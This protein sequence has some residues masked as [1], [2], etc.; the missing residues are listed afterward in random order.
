MTLTKIIRF[1]R[2][3]AADPA[4]RS[5]MHARFFSR[6]HHQTAVLTGF[7]RY[8]EIFDECASLL[9]DGSELR[10]LSFGCSTGE[11]PV[12]LRHY[13]P[14][15]VILG[16]DI[17]GH[18]L[19]ICRD[20]SPEYG[21]RFFKSTPSNINRNGPYNAIFCMAVLQRSPKVVEAQNLCDISKIYPFD[22]FER[23]LVELDAVLAS[24]GLLV[25]EHTFYR[26]SD[27][28]LVKGYRSSSFRTSESS[29]VFK[30]DR[31]GRRTHAEP[32]PVIFVKN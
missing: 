20:L 19:K 25:I 30:F 1:A 15:A 26:L 24:G 9:G 13:F 32:Q 23:Q 27:T 5:L 4:Y 12:T 3:L 18:N 14:S 31:S 21:L 7:N 10:L 11:E 17:N 6:E 29:T 2:R 16:T 28:V 22:K 8:P